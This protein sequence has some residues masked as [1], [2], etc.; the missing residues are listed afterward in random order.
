M[1]DTDGLAW[2]DRLTRRDTL[3]RKDALHAKV[4]RL[5]Y[6]GQEELR[7]WFL[8][9]ERVSVLDDEAVEALKK[10][11]EELWHLLP[12]LSPMELAQVVKIVRAIAAK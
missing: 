7:L 12:W 3:E 6:H 2:R 8:R 10:A 9:R 4:D 5:N 1:T 11:Q